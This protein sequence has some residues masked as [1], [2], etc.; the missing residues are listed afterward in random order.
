MT[1]THNEIFKLPTNDI[2]SL[3]IGILTRG[4]FEDGTT[5]A[6]AL[7]SA[8]ATYM[9][10]N[11]GDLEATSE[12]RDKIC[13]FWSIELN[14]HIYNLFVETPNRKPTDAFQYANNGKLILV[15]P[16]K[17]GPKDWDCIAGAFNML[18]YGLESPEIARS[19]FT[20]LATENPIGYILQPDQ[21]KAVEKMLYNKTDETDWDERAKIMEAKAIQHF[22]L[23]ENHEHAGYITRNGSMLNFSHEG[24]Q[25]DMDHR[26]INEIF[27]DDEI[28]KDIGSNTA[29]MIQFMN[30]GNIR[31]SDIGLDIALPP[32]NAQKRVIRDKCRKLFGDIYI[33]FSSPTGSTVA[34]K[35]F[36]YGTPTA[37]I[38]HT[39]DTYFETGFLPNVDD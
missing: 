31:T 2:L 35:H 19:I 22:G 5:Y 10:E 16:D 13:G 36:V 6:L 20:R 24:Y 12:R 26:D 17:L 29:Y 4:H 7:D 32:T 37:I 39:I 3:P 11:Q 15:D 21:Q 34:S 33:D 9:L 8:K 30:L 14:D 27:E 1:I 28:E 25:R 38:M 18:G 23:T